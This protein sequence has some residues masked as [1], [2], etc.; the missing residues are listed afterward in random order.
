N[1]YRQKDL[2]ALDYLENVLFQRMIPPSDVAGIVFEP[3][4][5]EGGYLIMPPED[6]KR[7]RRIC[8]KHGILLIADEVQSGMGRTGKFLCMEHFGVE[9]DITLMAKGIANGL[10]LGAVAARAGVADLFEPGDHGSTFGG[11][12]VVCRA[13]LE[14]L[15][16]LS[17][18]TLRRVQDLGAFFLKELTSWKEDIPAIR[19][20]RGLG[21]MLGLELDRPC[22]PVVQACREGGL[23]VNC[24]AESVVRLLP[25]LTLSKEE[26]R[27]GLKILKRAL[28]SLTLS[29]KT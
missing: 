14:V 29:V 24:T 3:I 15:K 8:D 5:G 2:D 9:P 4:Q 10:P 28:I 12:P 27:A 1:S 7:L 22:A 17:P 23:L 11:G 16:I 26:A 13:A 6:V 21:L 19:S 25:P 18:K 20:V